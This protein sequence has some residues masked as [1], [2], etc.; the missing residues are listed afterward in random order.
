MF[1]LTRP[2]FE[3]ETRNI[4]NGL[5]Q[6]KKRSMSKRICASSFSNVVTFLELFLALVAI[7]K[8]RTM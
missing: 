7:L 2:K 1:I 4:E 5:K 8:S 6:E 3:T